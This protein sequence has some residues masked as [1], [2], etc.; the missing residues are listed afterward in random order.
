MNQ[1]NKTKQNKK[2]NKQ[3]NQSSGFTPGDADLIFMSWDSDGGHFRKHPRSFS[4]AA[5]IKN[6]CCLGQKF[7]W[8]FYTVL[9]RVQY[10]M[11]T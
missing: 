8:T 4:H 6:H 5:K 11:Y 2:T 1:K 10:T 7:P 3:K 9:H